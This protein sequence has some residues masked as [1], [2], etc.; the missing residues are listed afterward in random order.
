MTCLQTYREFLSLATFLRVHSNSK[1]V[2]HLS[3]QN[4]Y[5]NL[6]TTYHIKLNFFFW[7]RLLVSLLLAKYL[8]SVAATLI[9]LLTN[10][11]NLIFYSNSRDHNENK[12]FL[13]VLCHPCYFQPISMLLF[14]FISTSSNF[15]DLFVFNLETNCN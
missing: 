8:I 11:T 4:R 14:A 7:T 9:L 10:S 1:E 3:W 12:T 6:K 15:N 13:L 5:P 2:S